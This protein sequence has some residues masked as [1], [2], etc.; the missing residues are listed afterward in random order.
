MTLIDDQLELGTDL[1][2]WWESYAY[3]GFT[4]RLTRFFKDVVLAEIETPIV[5]FIDEIDTTL[6]LGFTDD[7]FVAVRYF[8]T[9]RAQN[10]VF[11][12]LSF[13]LIGVASPGDLIQDHKRTHFNIG[14]RVDLDDFSLS[15]AAFL[16]KGLNSDDQKAKATLQLI[17]EWTNGHPYLTQRACQIVSEHGGDYNKKAIEKIIRETFLSIENQKN[18][19]LLFVRDMLLERFQNK[20]RILNIYKKIRRGKPVLDEERSLEKTHLKLSG[21][22]KRKGLN[23]TV[24]NKI[25]GEIFNPAWINENTYSENYAPTP[26]SSFWSSGIGAFAIVSLLKIFGSIQSAELYNYDLYHKFLPPSPPDSRVTVLGIT[27]ED[28][29]EFGWPL[30]DETLSTAIENLQLHEPS[31]IGLG[32][33]RD[34]PRP[35]GSEALSKQLSAPNL[36]GIFNVGSSSNGTE[37]PSPPSIDESRIGFND[38]PVDSDGI[39]RR[40]LIFVSGGDS[41]NDYYSFVLRVLATH[42]PNAF[43]SISYDYNNLYLGDVAIKALT[44]KSGGY[45]NIDSRGY[46]ILLKYRNS[47]P[48]AEYLSLKEVLDSNFNPE[49]IRGK[50][51][52]IGTNARSLRDSFFTPYSP[53]GNPETSMSGVNIQ[54][55]MLSQLLDISEGNRAMIRYFPSWIEFFSVAVFSFLGSFLPWKIRSPKLLALTVFLTILILYGVSFSLFTFLSFWIPVIEPIAAFILGVVLTGGTFYYYSVSGNKD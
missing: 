31:V 15:E 47:D 49:S 55:H 1:V 51:V 11:S 48:A 45:E 18:S 32:L 8:Y 14:K 40:S 41:K 42:R 23:L 21:I 52:L 34:V 25:Y 46:Q 37:V 43:E 6:S 5:I 20:N 28:I 29:I 54:A 33:Y 13:V 53:S 19:N 39:I 35:P 38:L 26:R 36:V 3:L 50:M 7:F 17:M 22:V 2:N 44:T 24:R 27:E 30:T 12:R 9:A 4:Q 10:P 16:S